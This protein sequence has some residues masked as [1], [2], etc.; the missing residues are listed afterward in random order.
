MGEETS[1]I[2]DMMVQAGDALRLGRWAVKE[3][4]GNGDD[5]QFQGSKASC[6]LAKAGQV[7]P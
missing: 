3:A 7:P 1:K 6:S 2:A 4:V 5:L